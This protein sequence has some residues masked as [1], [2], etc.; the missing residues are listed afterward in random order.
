MK[1]IPGIT[2]SNAY[3]TIHLCS[4]YKKYKYVPMK[5]CNA[6]CNDTSAIVEKA[7]I[8]ELRHK[9]ISKNKMKKNEKRGQIKLWK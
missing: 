8:H 6:I 9:N 5:S 3:F 2:K 4:K 1:V 7:L